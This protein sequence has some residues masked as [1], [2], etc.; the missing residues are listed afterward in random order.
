MFDDNVIHQISSA[1][2]AAGLE[3][4]LLLA[5]ADI[6]SAGNVF[7]LVNG[8][9]EPLIRFEGHYFDRRLNEQDRALARAKGLA[10]PVAGAIAN[11]PSQQQRWRMLEQAAAIDAK[12]AY[13]STSWGLGQ[14]MGAHW[15]MLGFVG[16]ESLVAEA[17]SGAQGQARLMVLY[18]EKT[19]LAD[20]LRAHDW[21]TFARGYNGPG[22][23]RNDYDARIAA[24]YHYY[25]DSAASGGTPAPRAP[26]L[27]RGS[28][29][30]AV[31][32]LQRRLATL[33]YGSGADGM[34]GPAT[35]K[36]V[37][38]FQTDHGL[39]ADGIAGPRTMDALEKAL[40]PG[41][42]LKRL[43]TRLRD[44]LK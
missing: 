28:K 18:I 14:V 7:A 16:I 20:A 27:R 24:A 19:G 23:R 37:M 1:A 13:E 34:Y 21:E 26:L 11:P 40:A 15:Q 38:R 25:A 8:R 30:E 32:E 5:I 44:W 22:F 10:S 9:K 3:P 31:A 35:A 4:S 41:G 29:G 17:R 12:A 39:A 33:G 36:M 42:L 43:W 6:E 2:R